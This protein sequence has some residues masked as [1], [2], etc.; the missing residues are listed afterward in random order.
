MKYK[1]LIVVIYILLDMVLSPLRGISFYLSAVA[2]AIFFVITIVLI[3]K[4]ND[5]ISAN[6]FIIFALLGILLLNLPFTIIYFEDTMISMLDV[7]LRILGVVA[8]Y[9][10]TKISGRSAK[11]IYT[12]ICF[13]IAITASTYGTK[14]WIE[15]YSTCSVN[16]KTIEN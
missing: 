11:I 14:L 6:Q 5:K 12:V 16:S 2:F 9:G 3:N 10:F 1:I 8:G 7:I 13:A 15:R 4:F